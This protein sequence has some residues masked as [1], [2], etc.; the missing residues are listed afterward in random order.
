MKKIKILNKI[1]NNSL[2]QLSDIKCEIREMKKDMESYQK[3]W[4][5]VSII[6]NDYCHY[7]DD[8]R[9]FVEKCI[10]EHKKELKDESKKR[11][12]DINWKI[13]EQEIRK[14]FKIVEQLTGV[15]E[16]DFEEICIIT[17]YKLHDIEDSISDI[18]K[19]LSLL[20]L[21]NND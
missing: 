20:Q 19:R 11:Y 12:N 4:E 1:I 17:S 13:S 7:E 6:D 5:N 2:E 10:K 14:A 21:P 9:S 3:D 15:S 18:I 16:F 8:C